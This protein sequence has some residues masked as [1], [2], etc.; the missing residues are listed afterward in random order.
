MKFKEFGWNGIFFEIPEETRFTNERGTTK[1][2]YCRLESENFFIEFKWEPFAKKKAQPLSGIAEAFIRDL[3]KK[4]KRKVKVLSQGNVYVFGHS[5]LHFSLKS[6]TSDR[7]YMWYCKESGRIMICRFAFGTLN[8]SSQKIIEH[9]M[10]TLECHRE[11]SNIWS[12][13]GIRFE[14]P[15]DFILT[16]RKM[17]VGRTYMV[18]GNQKAT[19]FSEKKREIVVEHFSM[20]NV[21]FADTYRDLDEWLEKNY[22]KDLK[23][24]CRGIQFQSKENLKIKRHPAVIKQGT[25]NSGF[26]SRRTSLF[27][28]ITWYCSKSN[29]IY[30][31]TVASRIAKPIPLKRVIDHK[32]H[33]E[34]MEDMLSKFKCHR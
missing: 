8:D 25:R 10:A 16:D 22:M 18:F 15:R 7:I 34:L 33:A 31:I 23:K 29:R 12:T 21:I 30:S 9:I 2:G 6:E 26:V 13:L 11:T 4:R 5:A 28:N 32:S 19:S 3:E 24:R 17:A 1:T 14:T 20:A 27:T